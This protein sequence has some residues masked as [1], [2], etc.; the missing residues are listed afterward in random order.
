M[1]SHDIVQ[2]ADAL[3]KTHVVDVEL[4]YK[5]RGLKLDSADS[6]EIQSLSI[7]LCLYNVMSAKNVS[8][9]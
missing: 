5:G 3:S 6:G 8:C 1:D 2:L 7:S 4:S 9:T